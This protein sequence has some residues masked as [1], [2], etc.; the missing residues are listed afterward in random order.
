MPDKSRFLDDE[1]KIDLDCLEQWCEQFFGSLMTVLNSCFA[2]LNLDEALNRLEA[3]SCTQLV[4]EQLDGESEEVKQ[5][6][7]RILN[8]LLDEEVEYYRAYLQ[9]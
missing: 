4:N 1:G 9:Q 5:E 3:V 7:V 6:A 8:R 2:R